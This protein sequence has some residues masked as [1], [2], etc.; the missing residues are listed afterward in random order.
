MPQITPNRG[1]SSEIGPSRELIERVYEYIK[2]QQPCRICDIIDTMR[3]FFPEDWERDEVKVIIVKA[4]S[5]L[6]SSENRIYICGAVMLP[7]TELT[8]LCA[9]Y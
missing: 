1:P 4:L 8:S 7:N 9:R 2:A 3:R 5:I 6:D